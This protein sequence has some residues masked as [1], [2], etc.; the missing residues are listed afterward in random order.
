MIMTTWQW[1]CDTFRSYF[2]LS[3]NRKAYDSVKNIIHLGQRPP[4]FWGSR[5]QPAKP[6]DKSGTADTV[7]KII[8][9]SGMETWMILIDALC[10]FS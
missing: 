10:L 5:L 4:S 7:I 8:S 1:Q 9:Q 3:L 2:M 6:T